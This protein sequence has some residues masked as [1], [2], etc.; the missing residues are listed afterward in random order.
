MD[1]GRR[2]VPRRDL[3]TRIIHRRQHLALS[4]GELARRTGMDAGYLAYFE[5][6]PIAELSTGTLMR[7]AKAVDTTPEALARGDVARPPGSGR[8]GPH[9]AL[10]TLTE[11]ECRAY[12]AEGG[13]G[14]IVFS[15]ERGPTAQPVNFRF[16]D[17]DVFFRTT[18]ATAAR[19]TASS[20]VSFEVD[21][22]DD[23]M[24]EGWSVLV[25]GC[26]E[27]TSD[28]TENVRYVASSIEPWAGGTRSAIVRIRTSEMSGRVICQRP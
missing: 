8:A 24:S 11:N 14:R 10:E 7:L 27:E 12:L 19:V 1:E 28:S 18:P 17:G 6:S 23:A 2:G 21:R 5:D 9:P 20:P 15:T 13:V 16:L 3:A 22:I 25:T 26:A 4:R